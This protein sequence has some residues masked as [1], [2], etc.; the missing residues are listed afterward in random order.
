MSQDLLGYVFTDGFNHLAYLGTANRVVLKDMMI[1]HSDIERYSAAWEKIR[2]MSLRYRLPVPWP[3]PE[4]DFMLYVLTAFASDSLLHAF[5]GPTRRVLKH[6]Y[7]TNPLVYA[8]HFGRPQHAKLLLS[9]GAK[10]NERGLVIDTSRQEL[11]LE[12]AVSRQHDAMVDLLLSTGSVVLKRLFSLT[13]NHNFPIRIARRLL[14]TDEFMECAVESGNRLPSPLGLLERCLPL[15]YERDIIVMIRRLVQVGLDP[16]ARN[17]AQKTALHLAITGGYEAVVVYL[18]LIGT[19]LPGDFMSAVSR[20]TSSERIA[21]LRMIVDAGADVHVG[22]DSALHLAMMT[23]EQDECLEAVKILVGAGCKPFVC[24]SATTPFHLALE[25]KYLSVADYLLLQH[26]PAPLGVLLSLPPDAL[27]AILY[28]A[29]PASWR[30]QKICSLVR[31]GADV[32]GLSADENTLLHDTVLTL[33]EHHGLDVVKLLVSAGCDPFG[34]TVDVK[35]PL[36]IVLDHNFPLITNYLLSFGRHLPPD[37]LFAILCSPLPMVCVLSLDEDQAMEVAKFL[38]GTG[39]NPFKHNAQGKTSLDLALD[40]KFYLLADFL[41][42]TVKLHPPDTPFSILHSTLPTVWKAQKICSVI[43]QG[44]DVSRLSAD[45]NSL[46]HATVLSLDDLHGLDVAQLLVD[47]GCNPF[48][49]NVEGKTPF[50][51][52]LH[53]KSTLLAAYLLSTVNLPPPNTPFS[54]LHS[55]LPAIWRAQTVCF[56]VENGA[57]VH[58]CSDDGNTLH[59]T[60]LSLDETQALMVAKILVGSGCDPSARNKWGETALHIAARKGC[61]SVVEDMLSLDQSLPDD[62]LFS[63]LKWPDQDLLPM[64][65]MLIKRGAKTHLLQAMNRNNLLHVAMSS[66]SVNSSIFGTSGM[67]MVVETLVDGGCKASAPNSRG[68]TPLHFAVATGCV[69]VVEYLL[70]IALPHLPTDILTCVLGGKVPHQ[71]T[72]P[73]SRWRYPPTYGNQK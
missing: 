6:K 39:C 18:L 69:S 52:A 59:T 54:I 61:I 10:V 34:C 20:A 41:L 51:L 1:L 40:R 16:A 43:Y 68:H 21:M 56:L 14:E 35:T 66:Y 42:S 27:S 11:P 2:R 47:A 72:Y 45:G 30:A 15:M 22:E 17:S 48:K 8:A 70:L 19:P 4:H 58:G 31:K 71:Y 53:R 33:D 73:S 38:V 44:T 57:D 26:T 25:R 65:C 50:D 12:V 49:C 67:R 64:L 23:L 7:R 46:L 55:A 28:S 37:A 13:T 9:H 63:V 3:A 24:K 62:I 32:R 36:H 5:L 60:V 29:L